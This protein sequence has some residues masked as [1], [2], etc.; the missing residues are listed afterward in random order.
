[1]SR[2]PLLKIRSLT[3]HNGEH[4]T[5]RRAASVPQLLCVGSACKSYQ[6]DVVRCVNSGG[7]GAHID[8]TCE[9]DFPQNLRFG[10][11]QVS[12]EGWDRPG[13]P[14]VLKGEVRAGSSMTSSIL[15]LDS[16]APSQ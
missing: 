8:W 6:P 12:C 2:V 3:L 10:R 7:D 16:G 14:F 9:A 5:A 13:D 1:M 11:A 15:R 4:T